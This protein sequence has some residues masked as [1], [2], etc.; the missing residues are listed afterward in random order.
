MPALLLGDAGFCM[1]VVG[2][3]TVIMDVDLSAANKKIDQFE[4]R[5]AK[6]KQGIGGGGGGS[7]SASADAAAQSRIATQ[8]ERRANIE[9]RLATV[10]NTGRNALTGLTKAAGIYSTALGKLT[11][12][13]DAY[14]RVETKLQSVQNRIANGGKPPVLPRSFAGFTP[15][16]L[17]QAA[18][19]FGLLNVGPQLVG[20][21]IHAGI[22]AGR[23]ALEL[24]ETKNALQAVSGSLT[25]YTSALSTARQQQV[26]FGGELKDNI[27]GL[28]GLVITSRDSG[29]QLADLVDLTQRLNVK[30]PEQGVGGSRIAIGEAFGE[31]NIT[32]L[33]RRFEIPKAKIIELRDVSIP[34]AEKVKILSDYLDSIGITS[35]A[36]AGKVDQDA[37]AFRTLG[38]EISDARLNAGDGLATAFA[39]TATG[40]SRV[41]GIING[42]PAA[43]AQL[44]ALRALGGSGSVGPEDVEREA[45]THRA[46]VIV[47]AESEARDSAFARDKIT[48]VTTN[49]Q[50]LD[51]AKNRL[52]LFGASSDDVRDKVIALYQQFAHTGDIEAFIAGTRQ[53]EFATTH[54]TKA[55]GDT[56][57]ALVKLRNETEDSAEASVTDAAKKDVQTAAT[58]LLSLKTKAAVDSFLALNPNI[59]ASRVASL[60]AAQGYD[61]QI[62]QLIEMAVEAGNTRD[63]IIKL[64]NAQNQ[65]DTN[66]AV[67]TGRFFG[68]ESGRGGGSDAAAEGQAFADALGRQAEAAKKA[69]DAQIDYAEATGDTAKARK[70]LNQELAEAKRT[71]DVGEQARLIREIDGLNKKGLGGK[72]LSATDRADVNLTNDLNEQLQILLDK[73]KGLKEGSLAWKQVQGQILDI[74]EKISKETEK[75][76]DAAL[77]AAASSIQNRQAIREETPRLAFLDRLAQSG[78]DRG[79]Q[80]RDAAE[81]I[82]IQAEQ[83]A[84]SLNRQVAEAG[85]VVATLGTVPTTQAGQTQVQ[86][87]GAQGGGAGPSIGTLNNYLQVGEDVIAAAIQ[88]SV[89]NNSR[90]ALRTNKATG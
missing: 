60:A 63:A 78:G 44:L 51:D 30:S 54:I 33:A 71:G 80:A 47:G 76:A 79:E 40:L 24:R 20:Q 18:G 84:R 28:Q 34:A 59:D 2:T 15:Q 87:V 6:S 58:E 77:S 83:R 11:Q 69:R 90:A 1:G 16:G 4:A 62:R 39:G 86:P 73:Q 25:V 38:Q 66:K 89:Q 64:N 17:A 43:I 67:A 19:A 29:A 72:G 75:Q 3:S 36:V 35:A 57:S 88:H 13:T 81:L 46:G 42:N 31:G 26:L 41:I 61:P 55:R 56:T 68:R 5:L 14:L 8:I 10:Q 85:G 23:D 22:D 37:I 49:T 65:K 53:L 32:S 27:E 74:Q 50:A 82:R 9:A 45:Q 12:G 52:V 48:G 7:P 70:L 21:G